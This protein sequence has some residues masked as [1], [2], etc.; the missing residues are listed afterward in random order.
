[1]QLSFDQVHPELKQYFMELFSAIA[2]EKSTNIESLCIELVQD[3]KLW[4]GLAA[5]P[6]DQ[7]LVSDALKSQHPHLR[8]FNALS[9]SLI[10]Q[11]LPCESLKKK[12]PEFL[13]QFHLW[14]IRGWLQQFAKNSYLTQF[15]ATFDFVVRVMK[16]Y[17]DHAGRPFDKLVECYLDHIRLASMEE[18]SEVETEK[19][20]NQLIC[21]FQDFQ[22]SI[23]LFEQRIV[24]SEMQLAANRSAS[25]EATKKL[26]SITSGESLPDWAHTFVFEHWH[27]F[28]HLQ[29]LKSG[30]KSIA[31]GEALL[32]ELLEQFQLKSDSER[33]NIDEAD[34]T[35]LR[36]NIRSL[37]SET[38]VDQA[39]VL[40][41][42]RNLKAY[43]EELL[44]GSHSQQKWTKVS[45]L[46][47]VSYTTD[48]S[49]PEPWDKSVL[50][51][52]SPVIEDE[53]AILA[54]CKPGMW[55]IFSRNG[56]EYHCRIAHRDFKLGQVILVNYSGAKVAS[57]EV[58]QL[59]EAFKEHWLSSLEMGSQLDSA[60]NKI[61]E[62]LR[63][64]SE[65]IRK[66]KEAKYQEEERRKLS[67]KRVETQARDQAREQKRLSLL[68]EYREK[69]ETMSPGTTFSWKQM[70]NQELRFMLRL[71]VS[72]KFVF[73]DK[74]GNKVAEWQPDELSELWANGEIKKIGSKDYAD[75]GM[76]HIVA[77]QRSR[78][79][80][81]E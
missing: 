26:E 61:V 47:F 75:M 28:F 20:H 55:M 40:E 63:S 48:A 4:Q 7:P 37:L 60:L 34:L 57:L 59:V 68:E 80:S 21:E 49:G 54:K 1:M 64:Q 44:S 18:L 51:D 23:K 30:E 22:K 50:L 70:P 71:K 33:S 38:V 74:R 56:S 79:Q 41:F 3:D 52:D 36:K 9:R 58:S 35:S 32:Q 31:W 25:E 24:K 78:K 27:R 46:D 12:H 45:S 6:G 29:M 81:I 14:L 66:Q 19:L 67:Q 10:G 2:P 42:L 15:Q 72:G 73:A 8:V 53:R 13:R 5:V 62:Y 39:S 77:V 16:P 69:V 76:E 11:L 43:H 65:L 17:D